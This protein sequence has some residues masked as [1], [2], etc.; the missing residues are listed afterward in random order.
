MGKDWQK[1][2]ATAFGGWRFSEVGLVSLFRKK[3]TAY[4]FYFSGI[5][6]P[7]LL[8]VQPLNKFDDFIINIFILI[9]VF[10]VPFLYEFPR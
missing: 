1:A 7:H 5:K 6:I 2:I 10:G 3:E 9:Y 8:S 4:F